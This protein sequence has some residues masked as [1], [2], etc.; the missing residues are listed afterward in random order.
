MTLDDS[1]IHTFP[2]L[3]GNMEFWNQ[4]HTFHGNP[5][6][7]FFLPIL[8][9][10]GVEFLGE[11][12]LMY[13]MFVFIIGACCWNMMGTALHVQVGALSGNCILCPTHD[14]LGGKVRIP[15]A[16]SS[17][18]FHLQSKGRQ[19]LIRVGLFLRSSCHNHA[20]GIGLW[21]FRVPSMPALLCQP[22]WAAHLSLL[23][24]SSWL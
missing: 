24:N 2:R 6:N 17:L 18:E 7:I 16:Q 20:R 8:N 13:E 14:S 23:P 9:V 22:L 12:S 10:L 3:A 19:P 5:K 21:Y 1:V 11:I 4:S 15:K